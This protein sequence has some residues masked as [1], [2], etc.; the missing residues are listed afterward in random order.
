GHDS[1]AEYQA[2]INWGD[3]T[4]PSPGRV[5]GYGGHYAVVGDHQFGGEARLALHVFITEDGLGRADVLNYL[6]VKTTSA[7]AL[8]PP[9]LGWWVVANAFAPSGFPAGTIDWD[10]GGP[11]R[12]AVPT[13]RVRPPPDPNKPGTVSGWHAYH[14]DG[15]YTVTTTVSDPDGPSVSVATPI[16]VA[17]APIWVIGILPVIVGAE[18]TP[19]ALTDSL[20]L[21]NFA[22]ADPLAT[23]DEFD[24]TIDW[25]DGQQTLHA[26]VMLLPDHT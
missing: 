1:A 8:V 22:D 9:Q 3:G 25:G 23:A 5:L 10:D 19:L 4:D 6:T 12:Y 11:P 16:S 21:V 17:A 14:P 13:L 20:A 2:W 7:D 15:A 18:H 26:P 24:V